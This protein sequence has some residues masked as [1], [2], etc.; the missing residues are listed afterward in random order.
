MTAPTNSKHLKFK[1]KSR[2]VVSKGRGQPAVRE[3]FFREKKVA[4]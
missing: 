2:A 4:C 1:A 3:D